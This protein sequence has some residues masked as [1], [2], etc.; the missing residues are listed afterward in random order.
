MLLSEETG[1]RVPEVAED[2]GIKNEIYGPVISVYSDAE[3]TSS[4]FKINVTA[5]SPKK[6]ACDAKNCLTG[7]R[8]NFP[9]RPECREK[10][11][12]STRNGV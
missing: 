12:V 8:G 10:Q 6:S 5:R 3:K 7:F 2:L 1:S 4:N 9:N 11:P